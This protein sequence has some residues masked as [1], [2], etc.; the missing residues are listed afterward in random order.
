MNKSEQTSDLL[1]HLQEL[2]VIFTKR[3]QPQY[4]YQYRGEF[5]DLAMEIYCDFLTPKGRGEKKETLLDKFDASITSLEYLVKVSVIRKLIDKSRANPLVFQSLDESLETKGD[6][7]Y[8]C[9]PSLVD[10]KESSLNDEKFLTKV[11]TEF[12]KLPEAI[13]NQHYV[14]LFECDSPLAKRLKPIIRFIHQSP[15]QQIT[16]KTVVLFVPNFKKCIDFDRFDG[17]AKGKIQPFRLEREILPT[18]DRYQSL[19]SRSQFEEYCM[20][21]LYN[22]V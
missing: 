8:S 18:L 13:R 22:F 4:Y 15:I 14:A 21:N 6:F 2:V 5:Y 3:Y 12:N 7:I 9:M 16:D 10:T 19:F 1:L 11:E 17:H 20:N